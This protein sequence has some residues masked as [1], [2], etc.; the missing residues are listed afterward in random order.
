MADLASSLAQVDEI[1]DELARRG[2]NDLAEKARATAADLRSAT[3]D[4]SEPELDLISPAE[5]AKLFD[6]TSGPMVMR[7]AREKLLEGFNVGG[8]VKVSRA[9]VE[10]MIDS[11]IVVRQRERERDLAEILDALDIGDE[12]WPEP[13]LLHIGRAP[14]DAVA[15]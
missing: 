3:S 6:I 4:A 1:A 12:S 15:C 11:H 14:W 8:R 10:R 7:W 9:S 5:A 2:D 13:Q